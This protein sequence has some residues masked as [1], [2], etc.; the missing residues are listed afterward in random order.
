MSDL[1]EQ[2]LRLSIRVHPS[3]TR[4]F[5][6]YT[7]SGSDT[8]TAEIIHP[9]EL[10]GLD[11]ANSILE[12]FEEQ[13]PGMAIVLS[14]CRLLV[15]CLEYRGNRRHLIV[16]GWGE[17][18]LRGETLFEDTRTV[19]SHD[20]SREQSDDF[21]V[22][23]TGDEPPENSLAEVFWD[24]HTA[25]PSLPN[26]FEDPDMSNFVNVLYH[27]LVPAGTGRETVRTSEIRRRIM[28]LWLDDFRDLDVRPPVRQ[29]RRV[30]K[31]ILA[32]TI[33]LA[34]QLNG[35]VARALVFRQLGAHHGP[36]DIDTLT[37]HEEA[38][39]ELRYGGSQALRDINLGLLFGCGPLFA[40]LI[41]E[42][43]FAHVAGVPQEEL[44]TKCT[45][46]HQYIFLLN[47]FRDRRRAARAAER[48]NTRLSH[49]DR[50]PSGRR[51]SAANHADERAIEPSQQAVF[52]ESWA[53]AEAILPRLKPRD[54]RRLRA[55]LDA[56]GDKRRAAAALGLELKT[57]S[58][59][60]RQTVRDNIQRKMEE[61]AA[62][63]GFG[64]LLN[65]ENE[66]VEEEIED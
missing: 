53:I 63:E 26:E 37:H 21:R 54:A 35:Y 46:L 41:N 62:T 18:D 17:E 32:A 55:F 23:T 39:L 15:P 8:L 3:G 60:W 27:D 58:R 52:N 22:V 65:G 6:F 1:N 50:A 57:F 10:L 5:V 47:R 31:R 2:D 42:F 66:D 16:E 51:E 4:D 59:Q 34:S 30:F 11:L 44:D 56:R 20:L 29:R 9:M 7:I 40:E 25:L 28:S 48:R 19:L 13:S 12:L 43:A 33:R 64:N 45:R 49:A 24:A 36:R 14:L 61:I 38:L